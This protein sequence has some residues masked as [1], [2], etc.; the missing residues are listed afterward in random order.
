MMKAL[1]HSKFT[2]TTRSRE[3]TVE[4][5]KK[6]GARLKGGDVVSLSGDLA[7]GKTVLTKGIALALGV[8][9]TVTSPTFT[10]ISEYEG[11]MPLYH[12]DVYR[13]EGAED[14]AYLGADEML[15][16][17]GVCVIEWGERVQSEL[18]PRAIFITIEIDG[19][20]RKIT[21]ANWHYGGIT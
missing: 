18:P 19:R 2:C 21:V 6:I 12:F 3:E 14:F 8:T 15:F 7:A 10:V 16:G 9:E 17:N 20:E 1:C 4:L 11:I 5:G 13:L